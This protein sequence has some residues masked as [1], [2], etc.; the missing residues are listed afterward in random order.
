MWARRRDERGAAA[1]VLGTVISLLVVFAAFAVDLGVQRVARRDMQA[2]A[3]VIALDM[4][5]QVDGR[6]QAVI[7]ATNAWRGG[8]EDSVARNLNGVGGAAAVV[9]SQQQQHDA[10]ATVAGEPL[11]IVV[12]MGTFDPVTGVF[13]ENLPYSDIPDAVRVTTSTSVDFSFSPGSGAVTRTAVASSEATACFRVGTMALGLA[14]NAS[15]LNGLLGDALDIGVLSYNGLANASV[16][17]FDIALA[18]N[19]LSPGGVADLS[20]VTLGNLV[21]A[22]ATALSNTAGHDTADVTLL[23]QVRTQLQLAGEDGTVVDL[24]D[25]LD[26]SQDEPNALD[27]QV[28]LLEVLSGAAFVANGTNAIAVPSLGLSLP[29]VANLT[30]SLTVVERPRRGCTPGRGTAQTSQVALR[31]TGNLSATVPLVVSV[32]GP[33]S[34]TVT[35]AEAMGTLLGVTCVDEVATSMSIA[36]SNQTLASTSVDLGGLRARALLGILDVPLLGLTVA[37]TQPSPSGTYAVAL[38]TYYEPNPFRTPQTPTSLPAVTSTQL[39]LLGISL[40]GLLS[41]VLNTVLN[42]LITAINTMVVSVLAPALGLR[43]AGVDLFGVRLPSCRSP[44]LSG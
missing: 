43:I 18:L 4:I 15:A 38:P 42:P 8:L 23:N 19:A 34:I 41:P 44:K 28:N 30:T 25:M 10:I 7:K 20:Q 32:T 37:T 3:D 26:V 40:G 11:T 36:V 14:T 12:R 35:L 21:L 24:G 39:S 33:I 9:S 16:S 27:T 29:G 5:R 6:T 22:S 1:I 31:I 2:L 13:D 17:A